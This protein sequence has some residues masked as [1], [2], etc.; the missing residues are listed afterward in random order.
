[1][2]NDCLIVV[3]EVNHQHILE[4]FSKLIVISYST[5]PLTHVNDGSIIWQK[6]FG[7]LNFTCM[8]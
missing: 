2:E 7:D 4:T 1:M 8:E 5:F 6:I 3:N